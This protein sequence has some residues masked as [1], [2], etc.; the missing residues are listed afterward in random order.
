MI[1]KINKVFKLSRSAINDLGEISRNHVINN[2]SK[3]TMLNNY[4][5][6]YQKNI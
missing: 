2:F 1:E 5:N 6:F 4:Y 3:E